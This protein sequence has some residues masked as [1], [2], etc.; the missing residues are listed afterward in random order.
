MLFWECL[1]DFVY[2]FRGTVNRYG[3]SDVDIQESA[4]G[5]SALAF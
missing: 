4:P 3:F 2:F 1:R 5:L